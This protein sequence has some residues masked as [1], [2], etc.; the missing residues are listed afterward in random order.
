MRAKK[1]TKGYAVNY[2]VV[3]PGQGCQ[4]FGMGKD[5][6]DNFAVARDVFFEADSELGYSVS[7][8]CFGN[9]PSLHLTAHTQPCV[10]AAEVAMFRVL[11]Q[12][13]GVAPTYFGGHS[14][15]EYAALVA[16]DVLPF[17]TALKLLQTRG[18][19]MQ[20]AVAEGLGSMA[21]LIMQALPYD[22]IETIASNF[23]IDIAN[24]N[25]SNQ[26]VLSG[27]REDMERL[28]TVMKMRW[29]EQP[30]RWVPL[31]V[32]AP[33][34]SRRMQRI[35]SVFSQTLDAALVGLNMKN[36]SRVTSNYSGQFHGPSENELTIGL[37][38]QASCTVRWRA[39]MDE[40]LAN[41]RT[42]IEVGPGKPLS[43][44]FKSLGV[45]VQSLC[46]LGDLASLQL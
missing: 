14:V 15:G 22:A 25:A 13:M 40:L 38:K 8:V 39:N 37:L 17:R 34:H 27:L 5:F 35:E 11:Q 28:R 33:F 2:A 36:A 3:F 20:Q 19:L 21:A 26:L 7:N 45:H 18:M 10:L 32:S 16:A 1:I 4:R 23:D 9:D 24:D 29:S 12:E 46:H 43:G 31:N 6:F 44:F 41:C 30:H 42:I